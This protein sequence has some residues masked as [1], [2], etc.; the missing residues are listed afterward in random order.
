MA[1]LSMVGRAALLRSA[2]RYGMTSA[3]S[4]SSRVTAL[5][6]KSVFSGHWPRTS[7]AALWI[8]SRERGAKGC[9]VAVFEERMGMLG[10]GSAEGAMIAVSLGLQVNRMDGREDA[11]LRGVHIVSIYEKS[12]ISYLWSY[13]VIVLNW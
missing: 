4:G 10:R 1:F 3:L 2:S 8:S 7:V 6:K 5:N 11:E 9:S 12:A 13:Q